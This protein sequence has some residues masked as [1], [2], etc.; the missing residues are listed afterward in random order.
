[1]AKRTPAKVSLPLLSLETSM[2]HETNGHACGCE[3]Q[4]G[5]GVGEAGIAGCC[6]EGLAPLSSD[7]LAELPV[8]ELVA[9]FR[10]GVENFPPRVFHMAEELLDCGFAPE[11]AAEHKT[12]LWPIRTLLGHVADAEVVYTH[13]FRR[14]VAE[15]SP[16]NPNWDEQAFLDSGIYTGPIE[17]QRQTMTSPPSIAGFVAT[18]HTLRQWTGEWLQNLN[19]DQWER[20]LMHPWFGA[21]NLKGL[22]ALQVWHL[23][24]HARYLSAK[25][26]QLLGPVEADE[27]ANS[28]AC[29]RGGSSTDANQSANRS[30]CCSESNG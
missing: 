14:A 24:H 23:E 1:M 11:V 19:A 28:A 6:G 25:V 12:G 20:K 7:E 26:E 3:N 22:V 18:I 17:G 21:M 8:D 2:T 16:V 15:D 10:R 9:R 27:T 4:G 5:A 13:R 29:C 30:G